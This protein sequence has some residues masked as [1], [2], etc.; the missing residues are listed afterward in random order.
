M[1]SEHPPR[2]RNSLKH[3]E[4]SVDKNR[5]NLG[6]LIVRTVIVKAELLG[7]SIVA[8]SWS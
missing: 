3:V 8:Y 5:E 1:D 6:F 4:N 7:I 2:Q